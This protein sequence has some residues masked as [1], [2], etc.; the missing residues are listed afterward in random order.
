MKDKIEDEFIAVIKDVF[1]G[2]L[3]YNGTTRKDIRSMERKLKN[4][5][6]DDVEINRVIDYLEAY[7]DM[8]IGGIIGAVDYQGEKRQYAEKLVKIMESL[9]NLVHLNGIIFLAKDENYRSISTKNLSA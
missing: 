2:R 3:R 8:C 7:A 6:V 9:E 5:I 4:D 1:E